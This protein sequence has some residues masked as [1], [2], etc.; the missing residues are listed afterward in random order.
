MPSYRPTVTRP[1]VTRCAALALA[2]LALAACGGRYPSLVPT[3]DLLGGAP[4]APQAT[5]ETTEALA[6]RGAALDARAAALRAEPGVTAGDLPP[7]AT[8]PAE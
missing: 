5:P 2:A 8:P 4:P 6:A 7:V 3:A 1:T